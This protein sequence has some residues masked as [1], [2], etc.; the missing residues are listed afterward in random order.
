MKRVVRAF[1]QNDEWKYVLV[2]HH[3]KWNWVLPGGHIEN[4][5]SLYKALKREIK[6][7]LWLDIR[8]LW[9]KLGLEKIESLEE[10]PLPL[11]IYKLK[12][13]NRSWNET[14]K[15]EYV[16]LAKIKSGKIKIQEEEVWDYKEFTKEELMIEI[17]VYPQIKEILKLML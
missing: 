5:E 8:I 16:F 14:K 12:Y 10:K 17:N 7:E 9:N 3:K 2:K 6:E 13:I 1:I 11:C 4:W 15:I